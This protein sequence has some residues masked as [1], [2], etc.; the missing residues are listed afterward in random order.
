MAQA[1]ARP[2]L[3]HT[4]NTRAGTT[5]W[6]NEELGTP[7]QIEL[8]N[9]MAGEG[10]RPGFLAVNPMGKVPALKHGDNVVTEAA[11]ICAYLADRYAD[12]GLAPPPDSPAR[13]PYYRWLFFAPGVLEPAMADKM[14]SIRR[15]NLGA[16]GHGT[17]RRAIQTAATALEKGPWL[18]GETF[19]AADVVL[20]STLNFCNLFGVLEMEPPFDAY[21]DRLRDRSAY[22]RAEALNTKLRAQLESPGTEDRA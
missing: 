21:L 1:D 5:L 6:M 16:I 14:G 3:Y 20:G 7:C 12:A 22:Q 2:V 18:L 17:F 8:V 11:A 19:S 13:G 10:Q 4:P 15:E 9:L